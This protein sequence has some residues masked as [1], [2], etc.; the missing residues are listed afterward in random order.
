MAV[1]GLAAVG[2]DESRRSDVFDFDMTDV[3]SMPTGLSEGTGFLC[4]LRVLL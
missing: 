4:F 2:L 1:S 3:L